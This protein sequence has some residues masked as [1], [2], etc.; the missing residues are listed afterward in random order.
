MSLGFVQ[1]SVTTLYT[2]LATGMMELKGTR[3]VAYTLW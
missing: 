3:K 1:R 2:S